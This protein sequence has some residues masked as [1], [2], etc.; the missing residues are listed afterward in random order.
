MIADVDEA[1]AAETAALIGADERIAS[2]R[3]DVT[4][5]ADG[6]AA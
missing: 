4:D 3:A 6:R 2:V 5:E 1:G